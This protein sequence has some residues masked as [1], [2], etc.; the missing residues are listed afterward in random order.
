MSGKIFVA[1]LYLLLTLSL[2]T[3]FAVDMAD[4]DGNGI[5]DVYDKVL[6]EVDGCT[7]PGF[8]AAPKGVAIE[9]AAVAAPV[10]LSPSPLRLPDDVNAMPADRQAW[11]GEGIVLWGNVN[12]DDPALTYEWDFGDASPVAVGA[13]IDPHYIPESHS[14]AAVASY[15]ATLTV[16]DVGGP[17]GSAS[18]VIDV[19]DPVPL[20]PEE[21]L[22]IDVNQTIQDGLRWLY[23]DQNLPTGYWEWGDW[24]SDRPAVTAEAILAFENHGYL[25]TDDVN[26][27]IYAEYVELGLNYIVS[28]AMTE[29]AGVGDP[30]GNGNGVRAY[31]TG[32]SSNR[33]P[34]M[35]GMAMAALVGSGDQASYMTLIED[36]VDYLAWAQNGDGGWGY[37]H[38]PGGSSDNSNTQWP[39]L[40]MVGAEVWGVAIP[41]SV[42]PALSPWIDYTQDDFSGG[43]GYAGPGGNM[44]MT[45][46][47]LTEMAFYGDIPGVLRVD[48]AV[49]YVDVN[50]DWTSVGVWN[51]GSNRGSNFANYH[52]MYSITRGLRLL[53]VDVL[54]SGLDWYGDLARG[55]A[56]WLVNE[57]RAAGWWPRATW[58]GWDPNTPSPLTT[59]WALLILAPTVI[60]PRLTEVV[61]DVKPASC[62]NPLNVRNQGVTPMAIVCTEG[63]VGNPDYDVK[64]YDL[65]K[66]DMGSL[67]LGAIVIDIN[68]DE[69]VV[70]LL[71][72]DD[73][74]KSEWLDSTEPPMIDEP[75][76]EEYPNFDS[77]G[78]G[79]PDTYI[80]DGCEDLVF[81]YY[82]QDLAPA[83]EAA[84]APDGLYDGQEVVLVL[85][86]MMDNGDPL[87]GE[88]TIVIR[89]K[90]K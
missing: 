80:G 10:E 51:S 61:F 20:T 53:G 68:G 86:G 23:L 47:I 45:G 48:A 29:A 82:T 70:P 13:V 90:G 39:V 69:V 56:Q 54:P 8:E 31:W 57:Q 74:V 88:D 30:D 58:T 22:E 9:G 5:P 12:S 77:D 35:T 15:T 37:G 79:I 6:Q 64:A 76:F 49:G 16:S 52:A 71:G 72:P 28:Q 17:I 44:G 46:A 4:N 67:E 25:P 24:G 89:K 3:V 14:Y 65:T 75:C 73:I 33:D 84:F 83:L 41:A 63:Y 34:L 7:I 27:A 32:L 36:A 19:L 43:G 62:P 38:F 21:K 85:S 55:Y 40:G 66:V 18:V 26:V 87:V 60:G 2:G 81:Y 11:V 50:W 59:S 42:K 1:T 78:D